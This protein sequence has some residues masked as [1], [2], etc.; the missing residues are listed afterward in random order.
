MYVKN[1]AGI[2]VKQ[3]M[4]YKKENPVP[5]KAVKNPSVSD[6][7]LNADTISISD[8]AK[9]LLAEIEGLKQLEEENS[10]IYD[11]QSILEMIEQM[12]KQS[13]QKDSGSDDLFKCIQIAMRIMNGDYI[14]RKDE[15]FLAEKQPEMYATAILMRRKN[16][17]AKDYDSILED[18]EEGSTEDGSISTD[19]GS[20]PTESI[21]TESAE[22]STEIES[23]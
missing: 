11:R 3:D 8:E 20:M 9:T 22:I 7:S 6:N 15:M 17:D 1:L 10:S 21:S 23:S 16:E 19:S 18:E 4:V 2:K 12:R 14:P 13:E 5:N